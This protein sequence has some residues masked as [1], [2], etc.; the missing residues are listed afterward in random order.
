MNKY[1]KP[2]SHWKRITHHEDY[3]SR[4]H[5]W[6]DLDMG[7]DSYPKMSIMSNGILGLRNQNCGFEKNRLCN[8]TVIEWLNMMNEAKEIWK[9]CFTNQDTEF[10]S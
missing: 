4:N 3:E 8:F 5:E 6:I 10:V 7:E 9:H 2:L 1:T